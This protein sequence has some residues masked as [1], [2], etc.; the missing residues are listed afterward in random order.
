M[1]NS[2]CGCVLAGRGRPAILFCL[3][4]LFGLPVCAQKLEASKENLEAGK[5][6]YLK[7]CALCHGLEGKGDGLAADYLNPRPRDFTKGTYK[8]R[9]TTS[10]ELPTDDDLFRVVSQGVPGTAMP[11]WGEGVF[12]LS[13]GER[14]QVVHYIKTFSPDFQDPAFDPSKKVI[15]VGDP[16]RVNDEMI[17]EGR[18]IY[19]DEKLGGCVRCH[20]E[21]GRGNGREAGT[22]KDDSGYPILPADLTKGWRYRNGNSLQEI[23]RTFSTGLNGTPMPAFVDTL[24]EQDRWA[25]AAYVHSLVRQENI[26]SDVI[27][28]SGYVEEA[29]PLD[30]EHALWQEAEPLDIALSGQIITPPRKLNHSVDLVTVRS[31]YNDKEVAFLLAWNDRFRNVAHDESQVPQ[32]LTLVENNTFPKETQELRKW[33]FRDAV[34][35]QFPVKLAEGPQKPYFFLGQS[36]KPVNLWYWKADL[37]E[38]RGDKSVEEAMGTGYAKPLVVQPVESQQVLGK[39]TWKD[40]EWKLVLKRPLTTQ[41][42]KNDIQFA[43]GVLI[44]VA[45]QAWD[46]AGAEQGL[47]CSISSWYYVQLQKPIPWVAYLYGVVGI[48]AAAGAEWWIYRRVRRLPD[49]ELREA[50]QET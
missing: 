17:E 1:K 11:A 6:V 4:L 32:A 19:Q 43:P 5:R 40:G 47:Q 24:N 42:A 25:L 12:T 28:K 39:G 38:A 15:Q 18:R 46:G 34:A 2:S 22:H 50:G 26:G 31:L 21:H 33:N 35:L 13:D 3:V 44:P 20:G 14:R 7:R 27:V 23:F 49:P 29:L 8:F 37:Q 30:P 9:S 48:A 36:N 45:V 16:P 10:G 41:D